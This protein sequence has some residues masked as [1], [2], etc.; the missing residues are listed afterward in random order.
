MVEFCENN[1]SIFHAWEDHGFTH[2]FMDSVSAIVLFILSVILGTAEIV[3]YWRYGTRVASELRRTTKLYILQLTFLYILVIM[4]FIEIVV[5]LT[6]VKAEIYGHQ[7][8]RCA[9]EFIT[10]I[11]VILLIYWE[12]NYDLPSPPS[13]GHGFIVLSIT[14]AY[15]VFQNLSYISFNSPQWYF[16]ELKSYNRPLLAIFIT[17]YFCS[18][19]AFFLTIKAPGIP[20]FAERAQLTYGRLNDAENGN[21]G[22]TSGTSASEGSTF[23]NFWKK[24]KLVAP[25]LWPP[26]G[27][28]ML[29]FFV[30]I[31][32]LMLIAGRVTNLF[33]P[34]YNKWIVDGLTYDKQAPQEPLKF[35]WDLILIYVGLRFLQG[36]NKI[37]HSKL[38]I[39][40]MNS[41]LQ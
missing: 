28:Y 33:V 19:G 35:R 17:T 37:F 10:W 30:F 22:E 12:R 8:L 29:Q 39:V 23:K 18:G 3:M 21:S 40:R 20:T 27:Q 32:F 38:K 16:A 9:I 13:L 31:C 26:R 11:Y 34:L 2:C 5:C 4:P 6:A 15:F 24:T 7:W 25:Y 1:A 41:L 36:R 14:A